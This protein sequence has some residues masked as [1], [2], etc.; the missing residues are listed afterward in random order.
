MDDPPAA[1]MTV[2]A[3][4]WVRSSRN[5]PI[6]DGWD[7]ETSYIDLDLDVLDEDAAAGLGA[8]SHIEVIYRFHATSES[9]A[10]RGARHPRGN[11]DW[12]L[13]GILAQRAKNRPNRL[14]VTCCRLVAVR[15]CTL[16]VSGLDAM[17]GTPV[18]DIKPYMSEFGPRGAVTQP[19]WSHELM[20]D[21]W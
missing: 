20:K 13:V 18:L 6:D 1:A 15:G 9:A 10:V 17:D 11:M 3:L 4:G 21:Y 16:E 7:S 8:F 14:G 2:E 19:D 5:A 12:P